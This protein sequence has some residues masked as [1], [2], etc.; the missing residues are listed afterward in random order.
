MKKGDTQVLD[1]IIMYCNKINNTIQ[2]LGVSYKIFIA[3]SIYQDVLCFYLGQIGEL[4]K[5]FT[6]EFVKQ[7]EDRIP[8]KKI[9]SLRNR[10]VH[11]YFSINTDIIWKI[12]NEDIPELESFCRDKLMNNQNKTDKDDDPGSPRFRP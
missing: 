8:F 12:I 9:V 3:D 5:L 2:K 1:D 6:D 10:I 11:D 4:A 7:N